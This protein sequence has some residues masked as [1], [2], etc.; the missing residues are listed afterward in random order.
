MRYPIRR[1][2]RLKVS[3][4]GVEHEIL[5]KKGR[6]KLSDDLK[7]G[8]I[9]YVGWDVFKDVGLYSGLTL[10]QYGVALP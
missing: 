6:L 8:K 3:L 9:R 1:R 5:C 10:N 7:L 4:S 2:G